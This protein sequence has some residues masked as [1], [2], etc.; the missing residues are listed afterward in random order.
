MIDFNKLPR[1]S[2]EN[3]DVQKVLFGLLPLIL[4]ILAFLL[5]MLLSE[6]ELIRL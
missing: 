1:I 4:G 2:L 6:F 5:L 3:D